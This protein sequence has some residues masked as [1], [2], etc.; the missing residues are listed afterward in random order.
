M[1][2]SDEI[3]I[4]ELQV[5]IQQKKFK[6]LYY[7]FGDEDYL[8]DHVIGLIVKSGLEDKTKIFNLDAVDA[9][10]VNAKELVALAS[11]YPMMSERRV[12]IVRDVHKYLI[13]EINREILQRYFQNPSTSTVLIMI[14]NKPDARTTLVKTIKTKGWLMEFKS[15]YDNQVPLWIKNHVKNFGKNISSEA[16]ELLAQYT[17][18]SMREINN[19]LEKLSIYIGSSSTISQEDVNALI[20]VSKVYNIFAL[21]RAIGE[22]DIAKSIVILENMLDNGESS[23]GIIV[24]LV[25][26]FQKLWILK[27]SQFQNDSEIANLFGISPYFAQEYRTAT[28]KY[29]MA[30]IE[31]NFRALLETDEALKTSTSEERLAMTLLLYKIIKYEHM[32]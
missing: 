27:G 11:A 3:S 13:S 23:L 29:K 6:C 17:G 4:E 15:L 7:F 2:K 10:S 24:M 18:N 21:Q 22:K 14:G 32:S 30:E 19:E 16:A 20:G 9:N 28:L 1:K 31:N 26:Y 5:D 12:V 8:I 25:K